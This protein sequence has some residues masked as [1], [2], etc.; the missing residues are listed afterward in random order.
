MFYWLVVWNMF[1][2]SIVYGN[3]QAVYFPG[4]PLSQLQQIQQSQEPSGQ[5]G[6]DL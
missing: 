2:F 1:Y 6:A 5:W 3:H 4:T